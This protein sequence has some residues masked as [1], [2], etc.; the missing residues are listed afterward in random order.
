MQSLQRYH[1]LLVQLL[2]LSYQDLLRQKIFFINIS[3]PVIC[4]STKLIASSDFEL[5]INSLLKINLLFMIFIP[6]KNLS[7]NY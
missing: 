3:F 6:P 2:L 1:R 7:N 4:E 5:L